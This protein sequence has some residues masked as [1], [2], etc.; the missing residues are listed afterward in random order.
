[1]PS[2]RAASRAAAGLAALLGPP[3]AGTAIDLRGSYCGAIWFALAVVILS[4][5]AIA[6]FSLSL[7]PE[8]KDRA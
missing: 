7:R 1:M 3:L 6:H 2:E 8:P 5:A 4:F